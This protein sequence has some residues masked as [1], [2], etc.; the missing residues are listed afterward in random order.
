MFGGAPE[1]GKHGDIGQ[2]RDP[3]IPPLARGH[4]AAI[5]RQDHAKLLAVEGNLIR[6]RGG[7][8]GLELHHHGGM[9]GAMGAE[10]KRKG[11]RAFSDSRTVKECLY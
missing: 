3:V 1:N 4:H 5:E 2:V 10:I 7:P 6:A 8:D 11:T 9:V